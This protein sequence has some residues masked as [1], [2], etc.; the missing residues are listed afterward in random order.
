MSSAFAAMES[1]APP[2][3]EAA[4]RR[5]DPARVALRSI[6]RGSARHGSLACAPCRTPCSG[7]CARSARC[8]RTDGPGFGAPARGLHPVRP[9]LRA[10]ARVRAG[11]RG[12]GAAARARRRARRA[13]ARH[14]PRARGAGLGARRARLRHGGGEVHVL[15]VPVHDHVRVRDLGLHLAPRGLHA[16]AQLPLRDVHAG[17]AR[18][19]SSTRRRRRGC[20]P[21]RTS[22][23][24]SR[25]RR[26]TS[27]ARSS[28]SSATRTRRCRACTPRRRSSSASTGVLVARHLLVRADLGA[29]P[30]ARRL[31]DRRDGQPL[32]PRRRRRR[33]RPGVAVDARDRAAP[34]PGLVARAALRDRSPA[35]TDRSSTQAAERP[36]AGCDLP[37]R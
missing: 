28:S 35:G 25:A 33:G 2:S 3:S 4:P 10:L 1:E 34:P 16:A 29:L 24:R 11:R 27:R 13:R 18:A 17:R 32:L 20:S 19:T 14:L 30:G 31:L 9:R 37:T 36:S 12:D 5:R 8:S 15:P 22:S 23:T 26:S 6:C 21:R 7:R